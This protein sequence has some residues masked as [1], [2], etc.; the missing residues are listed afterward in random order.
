MTRSANYKRVSLVYIDID[1]DYLIGYINYHSH[2]SYKKSKCLHI[3]KIGGS[4]IQGSQIGLKGARIPKL[5]TAQYAQIHYPD[6]N[7]VYLSTNFTC[8]K[9]ETQNSDRWKEQTQQLFLPNGRHLLQNQCNPNPNLLKFRSLK[10]HQAVHL[11]QSAIS[12]EECRETILKLTGL[13]IALNTTSLTG[14]MN[15]SSIHLKQC[16]PHHSLR[17]V[18]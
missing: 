8:I 1:I 16:F 13:S 10:F 4:P 7:H 18:Q 2:F 3:S 11:L 14:P 12:S 6:W 9:R 15:T 5:H 17:V